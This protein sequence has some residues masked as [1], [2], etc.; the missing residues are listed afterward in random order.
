[1][2]RGLLY[3]Q[4]GCWDYYYG[5]LQWW[6]IVYRIAPSYLRCRRDGRCALCGTT[7]IDRLVLHE[8]NLVKEYTSLIQLNLC[9]VNVCVYCIRFPL[10]HFKSNLSNITK[11]LSNIPPFFSN[12][13]CSLFQLTV[14]SITR[15][16]TPLH[17]T[18]QPNSTQ[19]WHTWQTP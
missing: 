15:H 10:L 9:L 6:V 13:P 11:E 16:N 3:K 19:T 5:R 14:M 12:C 7:T 17:Y 1:M 4:Y 18:T 8:H 2:G